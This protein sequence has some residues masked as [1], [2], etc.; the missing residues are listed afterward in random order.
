MLGHLC[1]KRRHQRHDRV[2]CATIDG[3]CASR[4]AIISARTR[5]APYRLTRIP[6]SDQRNGRMTAGDQQSLGGAFSSR[7]GVRGGWCA[8]SSISARTLN[9]WGVNCRACLEE[10]APIRSSPFPYRSIAI[11]SGVMEPSANCSF[12]NETRRSKI[13]NETIAI[14][15]GASRR[16]AQMWSADRRNSARSTIS[17]CPFA[18]IYRS[19][20]P[21]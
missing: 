8:E 21:R 10:V 13:F 17:S 19:R 7:S 5:S 6:R 16:P 20:D 3:A 2:F 18:K 15:V 11:S 12:C 9:Q 14:L 1:N 4:A